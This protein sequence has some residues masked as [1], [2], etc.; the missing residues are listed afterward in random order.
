M[1][2]ITRLILTVVLAAVLLALV[3]YGLDMLGEHHFAGKP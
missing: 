1:T 3:V 2:D